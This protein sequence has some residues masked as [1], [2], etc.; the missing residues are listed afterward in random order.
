MHCEIT[1]RRRTKKNQYLS[2]YCKDEN[3]EWYINTNFGT[4]THVIK[5]TYSDKQERKYKEE[6]ASA[7]DLPKDCKKYIREHVK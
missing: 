2:F 4:I 1:F 7:E 6:I 3:V 5:R